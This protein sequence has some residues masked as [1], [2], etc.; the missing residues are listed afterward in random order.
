MKRCH[1]CRYFRRIRIKTIS[2]LVPIFKKEEIILKACPGA[3]LGCLLAKVKVSPSG[4]ELSSFIEENLSAISQRLELGG[5]HRIPALH[6]T[7][8]AYR[9]LGKDPGRYR[10]SAEALTRRIVQGKG[11]YQVSNVVDSLNLVSVKTGFSIGGYDFEKIN[12]AI[13]FGRGAAGEPYEAI[14]RGL[15]N[16]EGLPVLRD[17]IGAFGSPTSDS[18]RTCTSSGTEIFLAVFFDFDQNKGLRAAVD[19]MELML[20]KYAEG[21]V[22]GRQ[23]F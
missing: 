17:A 2:M 23:V 20:G 6:A 13:R 3:R 22:L 1:L 11:L 5:I 16:I 9:L 21:E 8:E 18:V 4:V 10:P 19:E 14:G 15:L 12:G 7:R